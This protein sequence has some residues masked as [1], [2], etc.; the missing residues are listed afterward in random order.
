[1][2]SETN[3]HIGVECPFTQFVWLIIEDNLKLNNLWNGETVTAC[4][5][6]WCLNMEVANFKPLVIIVLWFIWKARNLYCFEDLTLTPAKVSSFSLG[7]MKNIP[8]KQFA[9][10]IRTIFVEVIDKT[11]AWGFFDGSAVGDPI[12]CG[13]GGMLFLSDVHFFFV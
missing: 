10:S 11:H 1:M 2:E 4:F 7:M 3:F 6:N 13:A 8:Q 9:V 5:K 12:S